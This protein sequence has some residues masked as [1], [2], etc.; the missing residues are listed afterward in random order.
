MRRLR[1][2]GGVLLVSTYE[3]GHQP[4]GLASP[5]GFLERAGF[6]PTALDLALTRLDSDESLE[7][8]REARFIGFSVPMH[9]AMRI[10]V[11]AA[12]R[13]RAE[14]PSAHLC[15]YGLYAPLQR[16]LLSAPH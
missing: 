15:F 4:I 6:R 10:A 14:N 2:S 16:D 3:L 5:L 8:V 13:V 9:T 7:K 1:D 11:R 12:E